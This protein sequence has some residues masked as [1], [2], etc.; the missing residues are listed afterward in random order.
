MTK[1]NDS[2]SD[3]SDSSP[4][5]N[6]SSNKQ[7]SQPNNA[8]P[9]PPSAQPPLP[10]VPPPAV[11]PP[12]PLINRM[13]VSA[14]TSA[15][16]PSNAMMMAGYPPG[17][18]NL[19]GMGMTMNPIMYPMMMS[20]PPLPPMPPPQIKAEAT[21]AST[22]KAEPMMMIKVNFENSPHANINANS[23]ANSPS[24]KS[25]HPPPLMSLT[26]SK[27]ANNGPP[28][29]P[30]PPSLMNTLIEP[31]SNGFKASLNNANNG[32]F[33]N[34]SFT[35]GNNSQSSA[36]NQIKPLFPI[37]LSGQAIVGS[38]NAIAASPSGTTA[39]TTAAT[40]VIN[41]LIHVNVN[42]SIPRKVD[43]VAAGSKLVHP[44]EDISL[45][46][47]RA[48]HGKYN[49]IPNPNN[50][51]ANTLLNSSINANF[52]PNQKQPTTLNTHTPTTAYLATFQP[53]PPAMPPP[54]PQ[55]PSIFSHLESGIF[56][57]NRF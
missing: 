18:M 27:L 36:L 2:D 19:M 39:A 41:S 1:D 40:T 17:M 46:E 5:T 13:P 57:G 45:E 47:F 15:P 54:P 25:Q 23:H 50:T 3:S 11:N 21:S 30:P 37:P 9:A 14:H 16:M 8:K 7:Q 20:A 48:S 42:T 49:Y 26:P 52:D 53:P 31:P 44:E 34:G 55:P 43:A 22:I 10:P 29:P 32:N 38:P 24:V 35:N 6:F 12:L 4:N 33:S 56:N 51:A 28:L